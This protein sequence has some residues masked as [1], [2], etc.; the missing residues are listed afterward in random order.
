[1]TKNN[2]ALCF[3]GDILSPFELFFTQLI[4]GPKLVP[5]CLLRQGDTIFLVFL[6]AHPPKLYKNTV[7]QIFRKGT[8]LSSSN[9][10]GKHSLGLGQ[11]WAAVQRAW[12]AQGSMG[13]QY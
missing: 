13:Q 10:M 12:A 3:S 9:I 2:C 4:S 6:A 11:H 5:K 7:F 8:N 1:M